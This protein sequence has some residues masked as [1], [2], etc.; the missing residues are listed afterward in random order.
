MTLIKSKDYSDEF[1]TPFLLKF[2]LSGKQAREFALKVAKK[3][4][5]D[6]GPQMSEQLR[7]KI[8]EKIN[9][10]ITFFRKSQILEPGSIGH[11]SV[12]SSSELKLKVDFKLSTC[13]GNGPRT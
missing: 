9:A 7:A 1:L 13:I 5:E 11:L 10:G 6:L 12:K 8:D 2:L 4:V 3:L